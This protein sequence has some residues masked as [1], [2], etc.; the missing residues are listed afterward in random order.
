MNTRILRPLLTAC[1]LLAAFLP[2]RAQN[3]QQFELRLNPGRVGHSFSISGPEGT[4]AGVL[5]LSLNPNSAIPVSIWTDADQSLTIFDDSVGDHLEWSAANGNDLR[6]AGWFFPETSPGYPNPTNQQFL[7]VGTDRSS[8]GFLLAQGGA[9]YVAQMG[10]TLN[11]L[12]GGTR[13]EL[14]ALGSPAA[15]FWVIDLTTHERSQTNALDLAVTPWVA[16]APALPLVQVTF[17]LDAA[18]AGHSF[19]LFSRAPGGA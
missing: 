11:G 12:P 16:Y 2:L 13:R 10:R 5:A 14:C 9:F 1:L 17:Y 3:W 8:H 6:L 4:A 15:D 7:L 19:T 18:E